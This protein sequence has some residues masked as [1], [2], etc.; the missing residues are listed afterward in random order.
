MFSTKNSANWNSTTFT[1][2]SGDTDWSAYQVSITGSSRKFNINSAS[3]TSSQLSLY[4]GQ[5]ISVG[6]TLLLSTDGATFTSGVAG[7]IT[8]AAP[9]FP[10][11]SKVTANSA[12]NPSYF[13]TT[14][15]LAAPSF[16]KP[17]GTKL[18]RVVSTVLTEYTLS[19]PFDYTTATANG[20]VIS[21]FGNYGF[22][23]SADGSRLFS[24][25]GSS[26]FT[27]V[28]GVAYDI[29]TAGFVTGISMPSSTSAVRT[30]RISPD[31][32]YVTLMSNGTAGTTSNANSIYTFQC[33][34]PNHLS[35]T[36]LLYTSSSFGG[37]TAGYSS[38]EF[39]P[40][41]KTFLLL[42]TTGAATPVCTVKAY[43]CT[44][45]WSAAS[46][47]FSLIGTTLT[48]S[49]SDFTTVGTNSPLGIIAHPHGT[50][51]TVFWGTTGFVTYSTDFNT[52]QNINISSYGLSA[53]PTSAYY[54]APRVFV[55]MEATSG[56]VN[57][58][59]TDQ[60]WIS[61]T[62]TQV[63]F[64]ANG[65]NLLAVG[66]QLALS[67]RSN[68]VTTTSVTAGST[69][70]LSA[71]YMGWSSTG[72]PYIKNGNAFFAPPT[73][74][75]A[76]KV[77]SDGS[78]FYYVAGNNY[79]YQYNMTT[80]WDLST[81]YL[82]NTIVLTST[83]LSGYS[84]TCNGIDIKPDG[85]KLY[86]TANASGSYMKCFELTLST[87]WNIG[88]AVSSSRT[89]T[90]TP[91]GGYNVLGGRF[92]ETGTQFYYFYADASGC[93]TYFAIRY[94]NLSTPYDLSTAGS[95]INATSVT[96]TNDFPA[97][98]MAPTLSPGGNTLI[99]MYN[100][101]AEQKMATAGTFAPSGTFSATCTTASSNTTDTI[102][103]PVLGRGN[104][105][106]C[107]DF[108]PDGMRFLFVKNGVVY[109]FK[110][111]TKP[112]TQYTCGFTTQG[113]ASTAVFI[114]D[115]SVEQSVTTTLSGGNMTFATSQVSKTGRA[116]AIRV[117][118][119]YQ[120]TT[121]SNVTLNLWKT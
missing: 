11:P 108:S 75:V 37:G 104:G 51:F 87:P 6:Q 78:S 98:Q 59:S 9:T 84:S 90:L 43:A 110:C 65:A 39:T 48:L 63:V 86:L 47:N 28:L 66:D 106:Q 14:S 57:L 102:N 46:G 29:T 80:P 82:A 53:A 21:S 64:G 94:V 7:A 4:D 33:A 71:Q 58:M 112:L 25:D 103:F 83:V 30:M 107:C 16:L 120:G 12:V 3:T 61:A 69:G 74:P 117:N 27:R 49:N 76:I 111:R 118:S 13:P 72:T 97:G 19:T 91:T 119:P 115:R 109:M 96:A 2:E 113:S 92:N 99:T 68:L 50:S 101:V 88:T 22:C 1:Q 62:T 36:T 34:T 77:R 24:C 70:G 35:S 121:I 54:Q 79:V 15:S 95:P 105:G 100:N 55:D 85:T 41:G 56:Q 93:V 60:D 10:T 67:T 26:F 114:P 52:K 42:N 89:M 20:R 45:P 44:T 38:F 31:G 73:T 40:D 5:N 23:F 18:W 17:D 81:V 8:T 32:Q 116:A